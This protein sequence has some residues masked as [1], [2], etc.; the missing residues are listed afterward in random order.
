MFDCAET[1]FCLDCLEMHSPAIGKPDL[2]DEL[3]QKYK[4]HIQKQ[5]NA[6]LSFYFSNEPIYEKVNFGYI[7]KGLHLFKMKTYSVESYYAFLEKHSGHNVH[8]YCA[9]G[10]SDN[11]VP[12]FIDDIYDKFTTFIFD[13]S[14]FVETFY[15]LHCPECN[16][17]TRLDHNYHIRIIPFDEFQ[18]SK[19]DIDEFNNKVFFNTGFYDDIYINY[20]MAFDLFIG[21]NNIDNIRYF[22]GAHK[23]HRISARLSNEEDNC[24]ILNQEM[25]E[26]E[27]IN[28][29]KEREERVRNSINE[30]VFANTSGSKDKEKE[31]LNIITWFYEYLEYEYL[32][33]SDKTSSDLSQQEILE[34]Y[35]SNENIDF[36]Y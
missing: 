29:R 20:E 32:A 22:L 4:E 6:P 31:L 16:L 33:N 28:K 19:S 3:S 27:T 34:I 14:E 10:E 15:E 8:S 35:K 25:I 1:V 26:T 2:R 11:H 30:Y 13:D 21:R 7:Y 12:K 24:N 18:I 9:D 23:H 5:I 17:T 36:P